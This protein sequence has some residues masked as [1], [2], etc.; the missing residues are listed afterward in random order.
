[1]RKN[2]IQMLEEAYLK[3]NESLEEMEDAVYPN[4][5]I[6]RD[7]SGEE[8]GEV[9]PMEKDDMFKGKF[10][11]KGAQGEW[12]YLHYASD[13]GGDGIDTKEDAL[14][15]L[16]DDH[17]QYLDNNDSEQ[18]DTNNIGNPGEKKYYLSSEDIEEIAK[19]VSDKLNNRLRKE[20]NYASGHVDAVRQSII[21]NITKRANKGNK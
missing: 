13:L 21:Y 4:G 19:I 14:Q 3:I 7:G 18:L 10:D 8:I 12:G 5:E 1:M 11:N 2:D 16:K 6:I 9:Y 15:M 17:D 20:G